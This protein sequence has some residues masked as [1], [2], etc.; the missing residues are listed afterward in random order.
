MDST[1]VEGAC[2]PESTDQKGN[3][4]DKDIHYT[5]RQGKAVDGI[6]IHVG[7]DEK[8]GL[9]RKMELSHTEEQDRKHF[10]NMVPRGVK[11]AYADKAYQSA[12]QDEHLKERR[13]R[14]RVLNRVWQ[15]QT[16][17]KL[18]LKQKKV[19]G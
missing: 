18:Q 6:K 11:Q 13:I 2:K 4:V 14:N 9:I 10:K 17:T 1:L 12:E 15:G 3:R 19:W 5:S 7:Q 8:S 16:L